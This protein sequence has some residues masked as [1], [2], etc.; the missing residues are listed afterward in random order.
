MAGGCKNSCD[1]FAVSDFVIPHYFAGTVVKR[2][3]RR[4]GPE[5]AVAASPTFGLPCGGEGKDAKDSAGSFIKKGRLGGKKWRQ[6]HYWPR[7]NPTRP[8]H[9]PGGWG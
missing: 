3:K 1:A 7:V 4:I 5:A 8:G 9:R 6:S 2:A